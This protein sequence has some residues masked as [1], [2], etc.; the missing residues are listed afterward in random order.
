MTRGK[1]F[2]L[3]I[4][5]AIHFPLRFSKKKIQQKT[6][7]YRYMIKKICG[8]FYCEWMNNRTMQRG[9]MSTTLLPTFI[10]QMPDGCHEI[11]DNDKH[12]VLYFFN[13]SR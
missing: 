7:I 11:F 2:S 9:Y 10:V 4:V 6:D 13:V 5:I 12:N 8:T 3:G 1:F